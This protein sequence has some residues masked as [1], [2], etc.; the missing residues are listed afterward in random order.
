M[1][2]PAMTPDEIAEFEYRYVERLGMLCG[3][4]EPSDHEMQL[5][6]EEAEEA[7]LNLR[8]GPMDR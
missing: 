8:T 2:E 4:K 1:I 3:S 6:R 7:I 5:A